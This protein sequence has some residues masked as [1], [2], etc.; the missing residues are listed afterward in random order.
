MSW[1]LKVLAVLP[2]E[3]CLLGE[4]M[5]LPQD[6]SLGQRLE[7]D[8]ILPRDLSLET[9]LCPGVPRGTQGP[10]LG[11]WGQVAWPWMP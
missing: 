8:M 4:D 3:H 7:E 10:S 1:G 11:Y 6:L 5:T 2:R 9:Q